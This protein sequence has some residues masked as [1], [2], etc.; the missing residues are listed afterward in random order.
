EFAFGADEDLVVN[1]RLIKGRTLEAEELNK[2]LYEAEV[3]K[4][5]DRVY[6]LLS[7]RAR[8]EKEV[9]NYLK[10]LSFKRKIKDQEEI[11]QASIELLVERA[12]QRGLI[13]DLEFAKA[14]V[15]G[16]RR[17]KQKGVRALR[18]ELFQK[19]IDREIIEEV[20]RVESQE[21]SEEE[22]AVKALEKKMKSWKNLEPFEFRKKAIEFLMRKGF[23]Y[24]IARGVVENIDKLE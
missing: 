1:Y 17:S 2:L 15:E 23:S 22:L 8:S 3:G 9:R 20:T 11:S 18:M 13:N 4:L 24:E 12:K 21:S 5:M 16:R 6:G 19:G 10:T 7:F 14:W